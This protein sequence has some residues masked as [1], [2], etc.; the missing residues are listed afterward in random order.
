[1]LV[2]L[3]QSQVS[4]PLTIR[5]VIW[6]WRWDKDSLAVRGAGGMILVP[7]MRGVWLWCGWVAIQLAHPTDRLNDE[8]GPDRTFPAL[9]WLSGRT[10]PPPT[11]LHCLYSWLDE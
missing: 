9:S 8:K 1:M 3:L 2:P 11:S 10:V 5:R 7:V 4:P 6:I